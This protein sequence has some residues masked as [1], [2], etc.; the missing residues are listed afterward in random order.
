MQ[1]ILEKAVKL[2][3]PRN[4]GKNIVM[5]IN[6]K[7]IIKLDTYIPTSDVWWRKM[8]RSKMR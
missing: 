3:L 2:K 8:A 5:E 4:E 7:E 1:K 6:G